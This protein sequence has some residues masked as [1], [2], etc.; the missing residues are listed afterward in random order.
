MGKPLAGSLALSLLSFTV[1]L[2]LGK[3]LSPMEP[4]SPHVLGCAPKNRALDRGSWVS[5]GLKECSEGVPERIRGIGKRKE[6]SSP[7]PAGS[8]RA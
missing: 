7:D 8:S 4:Q 6:P 1:Y 3:P 5:M 2:T